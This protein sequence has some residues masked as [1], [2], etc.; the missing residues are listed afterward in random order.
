MELP[1]QRLRHPDRL[2]AARTGR[3]DRRLA[4]LTSRPRRSCTTW[5]GF[6]T[7]WLRDVAADQRADGAVRNMRPDPPAGGRP[8]APDRPSSTA[9]PAGATPSV[10]VPWEMCRAYGDERLLAELW[11]SMVAWVD[12]RA[13]AA[14]RAA[15]PSRVG[16][17][18]EPAPHEE[19]LWD[20]GF[21]WGEWLEPGGDLGD[22]AASSRRQGRRRHRVPR[23][24]RA[25][26]ARI[27]RRARP[28]RRGRAGTTSSPRTRAGRLAGRVRR[29]RRLAHARHPGQP[30]PRAGLRPGR[31]TTLRHG[32]A[33]R[34]VELVRAAGDHLDTGFLAT[35]YLLPVLAD[36][37]HLD[38]AYELLFQD[39]A[40]SWLAMVDRGATT[41]WEHWDGIDEARRTSS[42]NHYSKGAVISFLHRYVAGLRADEDHPG[43]ERFTV[44][45][46]PGAGLTH[47][48]AVH[49]ARRGRVRSCWT[50]ADGT[51]TLE[52]EVPPGAE[53]TVVLP[54]GQTTIVGPGTST[55]T[56][57]SA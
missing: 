15:H 20:T 1:R 4:A 36:A 55:H 46:M 40:P 14:A 17:R 2:P 16:G 54:D 50:I 37:G 22:F 28:R 41:M 10:I 25:A 24:L 33:D 56:C 29:R 57:P 21:H 32:V 35:P 42:L 7:K 34:L 30:R 5:P 23:P 52:V 53:A 44:A 13:T 6:S 45:P 27:G 47:A 43:Y 51:F 48:E 12:S 9:R 26:L 3:L 19:F 8:R 18:P 49:D 39:T 11:P 38:V 31:P